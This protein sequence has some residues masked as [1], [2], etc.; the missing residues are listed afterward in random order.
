[1]NFVQNTE[2]GCVAFTTSRV[3]RCGNAVHSW[4]CKMSSECLNSTLTVTVKLTLAQTGT[5]FGVPTLREC[6]PDGAICLNCN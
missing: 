1:V 5:R 2:N 4:N 6:T 3:Q